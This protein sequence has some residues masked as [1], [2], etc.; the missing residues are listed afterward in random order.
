MLLRASYTESGASRTHRRAALNKWQQRTSPAAALA[1]FLQSEVRMNA[2]RING[3]RQ[4]IG[5]VAVFFFLSAPLAAFAA[6]PVPANRLPYGGTWGGTVGVSG[7]IPNRT[8]IYTTLPTSATVAQINSAIANCPSNQVVQLAAGT[9]SVAGD[10]TIAKSGV[11]LRGAVD[12]NG[13]PATTLNFSG[14][15]NI[16]IMASAW[17]ISNAGLFTTVS[18]SSGATRGSST[19]SL[20]GSPAGLTPGRLMWI[21]APKN[22]P[23]ID[24]G[25]WTDWFGTR[26]FTQVVKVTAVNGSQV[27]FEPAINADYISSLAVQVHYRAANAQVSMSGVENMSLINAAG[28]FGSGRCFDIAGADQCWVKNCKAYGLAAPSSL[29]AFVY[30]YASSRVE[31]RRSDF[32]HCTSYGSSTY[33][34]ASVHC[35]GLLIE[36]NVFHDLPNIWPMMATSGSAFAYNYVFYEPYQSATFLS[37]FV[38]HHGSH[39]HYNLFEG[40]RIPTHFNDASAGGN[41]SHSRNSVYMRQ[42]MLGWDEYPAPGGKDGNC[43]AISFQNHHDN[44]VVVGCVMGRV[45]TQTQYDQTSGAVGGVNSIFNADSVSRATMFRKHNYNTVNLGIPAGE[46]LSGTDA[47]PASYLHSAKPAWFGNRP[48]PWC[49]PGNYI[50]SN[51]ATNLPSAYRFVFGVDP[52]SGPVNLP[53]VAVASANPLSGIAPLAVTFSSVGS[54]DPEGTALTRNWTFGDGTPNSTSANPSHTYQAD[55]TYV[56]RLTV[57]DGTNSTTSSDLTIRVGNLPPVVVVSATPVSGVFPLPVTFSSVGSL[58]PEGATLSYAWTFGD[59][60]TS[61]SANPSHTY[62]AA[63]AYSARLTVSDGVKTTSSS[64]LVISVIDPANTLV[65][66]YGFE[67]GSGASVTDTSGNGNIGNISGATWTTAGRFGKALSFGPGA[68]ISVNDSARLDLTTGMTLEAWVY[69][70]NLSASWMNLMI[71]PNG[72]PGS[73]NPCFV[74][75]GC[76]G[77]SQAPS[78]FINAATSNLN[79]PSP[80]PLNAWSHVAS[81]YDGATIRLY[82]NGVQVA[83]RAQTGAMT[84]SSDPLTIGGNTYSGEHWAGMIDEVRIYS[85]ALSASEVQTDMNAS[86][87]LGTKPLAPQNLRVVGQ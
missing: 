12:A 23:T 58:D 69:P 76:A 73:A 16:L 15:D 85:R 29:N 39:N 82:V 1:S 50:Q 38:F 70:T 35:S 5:V 32:S 54:V 11:T 47:I 4:T 65:A 62:S 25:G 3:L 49:D 40:N 34:L 79:A 17:D 63:G 53:P 9:Y 41:Y 43:H 33:G 67:E 55:G 75:Q 24:G 77:S 21:S 20:S 59:G 83:S 51:A 19:V 30:M 71:K 14:S 57:S 86:V 31:I 61:T 18:V 26:P 42:R 84:A 74:L 87:I 28:S 2:E 72:D 66:S 64:N 48:W 44:A 81:T 68:L 7:G 6:D 78:V 52:A 10:I 37:Q 60:A 46:A 13:L 27:S 45:G 80:L 56:A 22:A 36:D 8:T